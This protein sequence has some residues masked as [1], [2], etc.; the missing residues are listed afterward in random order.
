[1]HPRTSVT[2]VPSSSERRAAPP[3]RRNR[4]STLCAGALLCASLALT[5]AIAAQDTAKPANEVTE[6]DLALLQRNT[7]LLERELELA[8][9]QRFYLVLD[10]AGAELSLRLRG[11]ELHRYPV[12]GLQVG[13]PRVSWASRRD[14]N[15]WQGVIWS[16]GA[17]DPPRAEERVVVTPG[18]EAE[19][20]EPAPVAIPK[21]AE[22]LYTVPTRFHIRFAGGLSIEIRPHEADEVTTRWARARAW[23]SA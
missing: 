5:T 9:G 6:A 12:R 15:P 19:G 20:S 1:M 7:S 16:G 22:E 11:A 13:H 3:G 14:P 23:V 21:T 10:P 4:P 17:L 8:R 2:T 18:D